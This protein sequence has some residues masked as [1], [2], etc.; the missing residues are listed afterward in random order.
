M[1]V[2]NLL[3]DVCIYTKDSNLNGWCYLRMWLWRK[4]LGWVIRCISK[5]QTAFYWTPCSWDHCALCFALELVQLVYGKAAPCRC[6]KIQAWSNSCCCQGL[7]DLNY[8]WLRDCSTVLKEHSR[9]WKTSPAA[10]PS[11]ALW[12]GLLVGADWSSALTP[13]RA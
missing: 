3:K 8:V 7:T 4:S 13:D 1:C 6:N 11:M 5:I 2:Y 9:R 10:S 12:L